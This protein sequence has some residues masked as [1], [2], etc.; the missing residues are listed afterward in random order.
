MAIAKVYN[1]EGVKTEELKLADSVFGLSDND[2]LV[3]QVYVA[4]AGNKRQV[5]ADTKTRGERAGSGI[6]P[7]RQKGTGRARVGS[8]RTPVWRKG[9][10][11][12]G[13]KSDQ[14]FKKKINKKMNSKALATVLSGKLR[15]AELI[16]VEK[17]NLEEKKTKKMA[18]AL[19]NL[20]IK[21]SILLSFSDSEKEMTL[22]SQNLPK[23]KNIFTS[24]LNVLDILDK[25]NLIMTKESAKYLE[26]KYKK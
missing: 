9:G 14:N 22:T 23:V 15:D 26:N 17:F 11:V 16:V 3:H 24:Q 19:K 20:Q 7:W 18:A 5:S 21:G 8:V 2:D 6:K 25:K 1:L 10:V 13:P 4:L 12:F